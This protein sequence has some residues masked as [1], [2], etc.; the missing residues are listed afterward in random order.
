[1]DRDNR[2][3][4]VELAYN[5]I[6]KGEAQHASRSALEALDAAYQREE[7][8]EFVSPTVILDENGQS[9]KLD[10]DDSIVFMNFR[11][12]RAREIS[13]AITNHDFE[14]SIGIMRIIKAI[15]PL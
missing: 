15:L 3:E 14:N 8:D 6:V 12:D 4:R 13:Q 5:L 10:K 9:I 7:T 11:A 1:M 2:W